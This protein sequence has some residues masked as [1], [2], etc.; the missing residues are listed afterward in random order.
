MAK[1]QQRSN[2][3]LPEQGG[4]LANRPLVEVRN[5]GVNMDGGD[6]S[7]QQQAGGKSGRPARQ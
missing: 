1:G 6:C 4:A 2:K 3:E 5:G 7:K